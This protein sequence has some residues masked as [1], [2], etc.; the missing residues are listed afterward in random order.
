MACQAT[1]HLFNRRLSIGWYVNRTIEFSSWWGELLSLI[2]WD[3]CR[4]STVVLHFTDLYQ[5]KIFK[6][7]IQDSIGL[8]F[9]RHWCS[10]FF[11]LWENFYLMNWGNFFTV[12][13]IKYQTKNKCSSCSLWENLLSLDH[14]FSNIVYQGLQHSTPGVLLKSFRFF[15]G[16]KFGFCHVEFTFWFNTFIS[17]RF[18]NNCSII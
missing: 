5:Q 8:R 14:I 10:N 2:F 12:W 18:E 1:W 4:Y 17:Y 6:M 15:I 9:S 16:L 7:A 11:S 3:N 13:S